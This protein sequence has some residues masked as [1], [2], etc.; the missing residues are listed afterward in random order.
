MKGAKASLEDTIMPGTMRT[1]VRAIAGR[2][3]LES[4][5]IPGIIII[6]GTIKRMYAPKLARPPRIDIQ[7]NGK[8]IFKPV[9]YDSAVDKA[10]SLEIKARIAK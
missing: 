9:L 8:N 4:T 5:V 3:D 7:M 10:L 2:A 1:K 6:V